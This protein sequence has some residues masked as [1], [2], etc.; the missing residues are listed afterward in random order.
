MFAKSFT[1]RE[2]TVKFWVSAVAAIMASGK[3]MR[4]DLRKAIQV[5]M[6]LLSM[7]TTVA[8]EINAS[9]WGLMLLYPKNSI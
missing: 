7:F 3:P 2:T 6:M 4:F 1:L 8:N 9:D 5:S